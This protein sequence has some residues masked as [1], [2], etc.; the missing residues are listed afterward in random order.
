MIRK[1]LK[2]IILMLS[3]ILT[4]SFVCAGNLVETDGFIMYKNDNGEIV[5]DTWVWID[6]N[7]DSVKECYRFDEEGYLAINYIG[8]DNRK[9]ND[10]GQL[11]ENGLVV[12]KLKSGL[13]IKSDGTLQID[14]KENNVVNSINNS[15]KQYNS[16]QEIKKDDNIILTTKIK[17]DKDKDTPI[18]YDNIENHKIIYSNNDTKNDNNKY[19]D[20]NVNKIV[21]GK[22]IKNYI[23]KK[24]NTKIDVEKVIIY[25]NEIWEDVIELRG[26]N[27]SIRIN[28]KNFN[29]LYFEVAEE[30][31]PKD[32]YNNENMA[33]EVYF[34]GKLY[35]TIDTFFEAEPQEYIIEELDAKEV[36]FRVKILGN[37]KNRRVYIGDGRLKKLRENH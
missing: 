36:E 10:K 9:T 30:N 5:K 2:I 14:E 32:F 13:I 4:V 24:N 18:A 22:N 26:N 23:T 16:I 35:D 11:I 20:K 17:N 31:H 6:T 7:N 27:S 25:G 34:D 28:T 8:H 3:V 29:Y 12:R 37:N 19:I 21:V 15:V 33:L 1:K